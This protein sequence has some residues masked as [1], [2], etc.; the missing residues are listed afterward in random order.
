LIFYSKDGK[1]YYSV[2]FDCG[3]NFREPTEVL[4]LGGSIE[5][6]QLNVRDDQYVVA[7]MISDPVTKSKIKKAATGNINDE[8]N[9]CSCNECTRDQYTQNPISVS[10]GYRPY[11]N[12][13]TN[14]EEGVESVD[15]VTQVDTDYNEGNEDEKRSQDDGPY[16][17]LYCHG[18]M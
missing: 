2:S 1:L 16:Y 11:I 12:P 7:L 5:N 15:Y 6:M 8:K 13:D 17:R 10:A 9:E 18:H 3:Q 14:Q 4:S